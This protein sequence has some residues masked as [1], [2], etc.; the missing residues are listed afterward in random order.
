MTSNQTFIY[1]TWFSSAI[2][3]LVGKNIKL[4]RHC[5]LNEKCPFIFGKI[6]CQNQRADFESE[7]TERAL[8]PS[9][10][11]FTSNLRAE[12]ELKGKKIKTKMIFVNLKNLDIWKRSQSLCIIKVRLSFSLSNYLLKKSA[13]IHNFS[14]L[15]SILNQCQM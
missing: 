15:F 10:G 1:Y 4:Y 2:L 5:P 3:S 14:C 12:F 8:V 9:V 13:I 11:I 6:Q 7:G